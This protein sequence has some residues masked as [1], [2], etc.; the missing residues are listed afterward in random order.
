MQIFTLL[1]LKQES[2]PDIR[3][4]IFLFEAQGTVCFPR[5]CRLASQDFVAICS[6]QVWAGYRYA[7]NYDRTKLNHEDRLWSSREIG[8]PCAACLYAQGFWSGWVLFPACKFMSAVSEWD[9]YYSWWT[10]TS[11]PFLILCKNKPELLWTCSFVVRPSP[12]CW[13]GHCE[14]M[15]DTWVSH[16]GLKYAILCDDP[17]VRLWSELYTIKKI[18]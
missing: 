10:A 18:M 1:L 11:K 14:W 12:S 6:A 5:P 8:G 7:F 15:P 16:C 3:N 13:S 9:H 17:G 2:I 4:G